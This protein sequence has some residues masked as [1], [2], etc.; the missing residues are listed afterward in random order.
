MHAHRHQRAHSHTHTHTHTCD[1][2]K[3]LDSLK[4][5]VLDGHD[6]GIS[7]QL[8]R[9]VVDELSVKKDKRYHVSTPQD[10]LSEERDWALQHDTECVHVAW[11]AGKEDEE[12]D[13]EKGYR[14]EVMQVR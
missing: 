3:S 10:K 6:S 5:C 1:K 12:W 9:V 2:C 7:K 13:Q 4:V 11:E 8:L 14:T